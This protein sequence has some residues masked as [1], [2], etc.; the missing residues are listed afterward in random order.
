MGAGPPLFP[1]VRAWMSEKRETSITSVRVRDSR[2]EQPVDSGRR[3][4]ARP[5]P[6]GFLFFPAHRSV[7]GLGDSGG[8]P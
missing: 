7:G 5:G 6:A 8:D 3:G 1:Q 4:K 2:E